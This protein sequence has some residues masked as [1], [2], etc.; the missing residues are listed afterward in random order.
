MK[1]AILFFIFLYYDIKK[2]D[3]PFSKS[4]LIDYSFPLEGLRD[5]FIFLVPIATFLL[6]GHKFR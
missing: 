4:V 6:V 3:L 1:N 5:V 2:T